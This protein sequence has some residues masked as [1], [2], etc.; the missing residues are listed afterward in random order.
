MSAVAD[1]FNGF[2]TTAPPKQVYIYQSGDG[3]SY[4][5]ETWIWAAIIGGGCLGG[6]LALTVIILSIKGCVS[7]FS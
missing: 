6:I 7:L 5:D 4:Y 3:A 1:F 2:F